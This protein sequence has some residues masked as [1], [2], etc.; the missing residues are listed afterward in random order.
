MRPA[1]LNVND[2]LIGNSIFVET[3]QSNLYYFEIYLTHWWTNYCM[4]YWLD[5]HVSV[6]VKL[7][8]SSSLD[9]IYCAGFD[10]NFL[11]SVDDPYKYKHPF[12][13][14]LREILHIIK[15][16][17]N[18]TLFTKIVCRSCR[19]KSWDL[20]LSLSILF[21][22]NIQKNTFQFIDSRFNCFGGKNI[23]KK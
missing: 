12:S 4:T 9:V 21:Q 19:W 3:T 17:L 23:Y 2:F 10:P 11:C 7:L 16:V 8:K 5:C 15:H 1:T 6:S 22:F 18:N 20:V 14:I 13:K